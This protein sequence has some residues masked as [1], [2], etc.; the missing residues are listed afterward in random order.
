MAVA[1]IVQLHFSGAYLR[2]RVQTQQRLLLGCSD[3]CFLYVHGRMEYTVAA[4]RCCNPRRANSV[5][6]QTYLFSFVI[7]GCLCLSLSLSL[8][9]SAFLHL[10]LYPDITV[11]V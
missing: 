4:A 8:C 9:L 6:Q 3:L 7:A 11:T 1:V 5:V 10:S 2:R